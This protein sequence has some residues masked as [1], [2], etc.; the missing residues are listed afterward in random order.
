M[1]EREGE[2]GERERE[3]PYLASVF[4]VSNAS[5][6]CGHRYCIVRGIVFQTHDYQTA[7]ILKEKGSHV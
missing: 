1:R 3:I 2:R 6:S 5:H 7:A 4:D